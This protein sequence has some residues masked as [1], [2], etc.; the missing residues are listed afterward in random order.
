M[1]SARS[2]ALGLV[3]TPL[4]D[5]DES[6]I[7][8]DLDDDVEDLIRLELAKPDLP[9][10]VESD[11]DADSKAEPVVAATSSP[12]RPPKIPE[13][14]IHVASAPSGLIASATTATAAASQDHH[15]PL[16]SSRPASSTAVAP[17]RATAAGS[18]PPP[19]AISLTDLEH[20]TQHIITAAQQRTDRQFQLEQATLLATA[21]DRAAH[22]AR[23]ALHTQKRHLAVLIDAGDTDLRVRLDTERDRTTAL[24]AKATATAAALRDMATAWRTRRDVLDHARE[25][26]AAAAARAA[27]TVAARR[28]EW[29]TV[30]ADLR[31]LEALHVRELDRAEMLRAAKEEADGARA[32]RASTFADAGQ[33]HLALNE[34]M[35]TVLRPAQMVV[36]GGGTAGGLPSVAEEG[37]QPEMM[38]D[39]TKY[40]GLKMVAASAKAVATVA[41]LDRNSNAYAVD[42]S[43][44]QIKNMDFLT[45]A[46]KIKILCMSKNKI[47]DVKMIEDLS[48]L[49]WL[50][51]SYNPLLKTMDLPTQFYFLVYL[52]VS[53]CGLQTVPNLGLPV[54]ME[55][56]MSG[57]QLTELAV[58]CWV[59]LLET[60]IADHNGIQKIWPLDNCP[61]LRT[62]SLKNNRV[63]S[64][65]ELL[66]LVTCQNLTTVNLLGNEIASSPDR[67]A[68]AHFF[69]AWMPQRD[70]A[71]TPIERESLDRLLFRALTRSLTTRYCAIKD[72]VISGDMEILDRVL[73]D[74]KQLITNIGDIHAQFLDLMCILKGEPLP[75]L[76]AVTTA[77]TAAFTTPSSLDISARESAAYHNL[78]HLCRQC[79]D[80]NLPDMAHAVYGRARA[81]LVDAHGYQL[82]MRFQAQARGFL[83][84]MRCGQWIH[85]IVGLQRRWRAMLD[86]RKREEV[87]RRERA[88]AKVQAVWRGWRV[89]RVVAFIRGLRD[90]RAIKDAARVDVDDDEVN[91]EDLDELSVVEP[92]ADLENLLDDGVLQQLDAVVQAFP[93]HA[94]LV[95]HV[96]GLSGAPSFDTDRDTESPS[97]HVQSPGPLLDSL[98]PAADEVD[99]VRDTAMDRRTTKLAT[100]HNGARFAG[101]GYG[102]GAKWTAAFGGVFGKLSPLDAMAEQKPDSET[103]AVLVAQRK[104]MEAYAH[105]LKLSTTTAAHSGTAGT[106]DDDSGPVRPFR[107]GVRLSL[108]LGRGGIA[109]LSVR[110]GTLSKTG[111]WPSDPAPGGSGLDAPD[112]RRGHAGEPLEQQGE[113]AAVDGVGDASSQRSSRVPVAG[114]GASRRESTTDGGSRWSPVGPGGLARLPPI[115]ASSREDIEEEEEEGGSADMG[116]GDEPRSAWPE[117][118][119]AEWDFGPVAE[120]FAAG[121][122]DDGAGDSPER[123]R[124]DDPHTKDPTASWRSATAATSWVSSSLS[125]THARAHFDPV[126]PPPGRHPPPPLAAPASVKFIWDLNLT[127]PP[128]PPPPDAD[129]VHVATPPAPPST[130]FPPLR[131]N[132]PVVARARH[133]YSA[134]LAD[135]RLAAAAAEAEDHAVLAHILRHGVVGTASP[136]LPGP[137]QAL[138][139]PPVLAVGNVVRASERLDPT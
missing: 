14:E 51:L 130:K 59:P 104:Q 131:Q 18:L 127:A 47:S 1:H 70:A 132:V 74:A 111:K 139:L 42:L 135:L 19:E 43:N 109:G 23:T 76:P 17:A 34:G 54:L 122:F 13:P 121:R 56:H 46:A 117:E 82:A 105:D 107:S 89:R 95:E 87:E 5:D 28:A 37:T 24:T 61:M 67:A 10:V 133:L 137:P 119:R 93:S 86:S 103:L 77:T 3:P 68:V 53:Y 134:T 4:H 102:L 113:A 38:L 91:L 98:R 124:T 11:E 36:R 66:S 71:M 32:R 44:N 80:G 39:L 129:F 26:A 60:L 112:L 50:D 7:E 78:T 96:A 123:T 63:F 72:P 58:P 27:R 126:R 100:P 138:V 94:S 114:S 120:S 118:A 12:A 35:A 69:P 79:M 108:D 29:A 136:S 31:A 48:S 88:A 84:R 55:L 125:S 97:A 33:W 57:N 64:E 6:D 65:H 9:D 99:G 20:L 106:D 30:D 75:A 115:G 2:S 90:E 40:S 16:P 62:L 49:M 83:A 45:H 81:R 52:N 101:L 73:V 85:A 25:T 116:A 22:R 8:S 110:R 21:A 92:A 128:P 15:R 41:G